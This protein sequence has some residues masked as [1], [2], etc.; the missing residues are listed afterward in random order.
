MIGNDIRI[1]LVVGLI[2]YYINKQ[3]MKNGWVLQIN[4][5]FWS[6][7]V[8]HPHCERKQWTLRIQLIERLRKEMWVIIQ[9]LR[10]NDSSKE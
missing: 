8:N 3:Q 2:P 10:E 4:A 6:L 1:W 5:L 9:H 7:E